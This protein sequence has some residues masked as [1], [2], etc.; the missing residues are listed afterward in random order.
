MA[1]FGLLYLN[2]GSWN[3]QQL[4]PQSVVHDALNSPLPPSLPRSKGVDANML[5]DIRSYGGGK[6]QEDHLGCY[7]S[8]W[9]LNRPDPSGKLL[10]PS[11]PPDAF[12]AIGNGGVRTMIVIPSLSI[13]A[14]WNNSS[15]KPLP[16]SAGGREQMDAAL[17]PLIAAIQP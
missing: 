17:T 11:L 2:G 16:I 5:P 8:L 10:W 4:L 14:S 13:V 7:S 12:A 9:W 15:L 3:G 1:R 6:N